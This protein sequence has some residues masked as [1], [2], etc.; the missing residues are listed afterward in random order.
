MTAENEGSEVAPRL[1]AADVLNHNGT[2]HHVYRVEINASM[3][4]IWAAITDPEWTVRYGYRGRVQME[5]RVGG[6]Y[7]VHKPKG[8]HVAG[9]DGPTPAPEVLVT[10]IVTEYESPRRL[11]ILMRFLIDN[12]TA[13]EPATHVS[14][15]VDPVSDAQCSLTIVHDVD[16]APRLSAVVSGALRDR[17]AGGGH[18]SMLADLK[19]LLEGDDDVR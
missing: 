14:Y 15:E 3:E 7:L 6:E 2:T 13:A 12:E 5:H 1:T 4:R 11:G 8:L 16:G 19:R 9:D 17:G 18:P 10:G